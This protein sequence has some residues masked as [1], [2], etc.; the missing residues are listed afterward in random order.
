LLW[1]LA[2]FGDVVSKG[3]QK[4]QEATASLTQLRPD[5]FERL[6]KKMLEG[7]SVSSECPQVVISAYSRTVL[8]KNLAGNVSAL[9]ILLNCSWCSKLVV[10]VG[11]NISIRH[12]PVLKNELLRG[13]VRY[14][15]VELR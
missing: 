8:T 5:S 15:S 3:P 13:R 6:A 4:F 7:L 14:C 12:A 1:P 10:E 2:A 9:P 11:I